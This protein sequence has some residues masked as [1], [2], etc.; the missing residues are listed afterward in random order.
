MYK[1][2]DRVVDNR[3][4]AVGV[5]RAIGLSGF[6]EIEYDSGHYM[7]VSP[8]YALLC[9]SPSV[10]VTTVPMGTLNYDAQEGVLDLVQAKLATKP[11]CQCGVDKHGFANHS[12]WCDAA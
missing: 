1:V 5:V 12:P 10:T 7:L 3:N 2:G 6:F 8:V 9:L 11:V 4:G